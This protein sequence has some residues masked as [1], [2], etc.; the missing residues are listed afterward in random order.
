MIKAVLW[1]LDGT[2]LDT[3]ELILESY[4]YAFRKV[5]KAEIDEKE[6]L[7]NFGRTLF[8]AMNLYSPENAETLIECYREYNHKHHDKKI[9]PFPGIMDA[10]ANVRR[11]GFEQAVVTSKTEWLSKRGLELFALDGYIDEIIGFESTKEHKPK[12]DPAIEAMKRFKIKPDEAIFVGDSSADEGCAKDAGVAFVAAL[13]G[14]NINFVE[15]C[16]AWAKIEDPRDVLHLI[17]EKGPR[18]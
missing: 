15:N 9:R 1:D 13:W 8:D 14:P 12:G 16:E 10:L 4:R 11:R 17:P 5:L 18:I 2:I 6:A 3:T 7:A